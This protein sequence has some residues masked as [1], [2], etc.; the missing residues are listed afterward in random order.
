MHIILA[1]NKFQ[2][3]TISFVGKHFYNNMYAT[4]LNK[5]LFNLTVISIHIHNGNAGWF[6]GKKSNK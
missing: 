2:K 4:S 6:K 5:T 1:A 3:P